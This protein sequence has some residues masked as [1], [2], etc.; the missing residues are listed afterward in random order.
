MFGPVQS[1][2][3]HS[4][5]MRSRT[6]GSIQYVDSSSTTM[7]NAAMRILAGVNKVREELNHILRLL[8]CS[9]DCQDRGF[10]EYRAGVWQVME[11]W[12]AMIQQDRPVDDQPLQLF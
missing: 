8:D 4:L 10:A 11:V 1:A 5:F 9:Q 12:C 3:Q 6:S 2:M 7:E